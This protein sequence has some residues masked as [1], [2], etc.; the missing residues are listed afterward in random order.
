MIQVYYL[1]KYPITSNAYSIS[2]TEEWNFIKDKQFDTIDQAKDYIK[3][4]TKTN[5]EFVLYSFGFDETKKNDLL[6]K[7]CFSGKYV[8]KLRYFLEPCKEEII[9]RLHQDGVK[10]Q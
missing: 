9:N 8:H 3:S 10:V 4:K 5:P 6:E 1:E 7:F 2:R